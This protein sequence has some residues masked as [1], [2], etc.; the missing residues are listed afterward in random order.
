M[1]ELT[2]FVG[3]AVWA[4]FF[5][6]NVGAAAYLAQR[7]EC[8]HGNYYTCGHCAKDGEVGPHSRLEDLP[9]TNGDFFVRSLPG[10]QLL[11]WWHRPARMR[12]L[13][14][15]NAQQSKHAQVTAASMQAAQDSY[16]IGA[17]YPPFPPDHT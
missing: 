3:V 13:R 6:Y 8:R 11:L 17:T 10:P 9:L 2:L 12:R 5:L 4:I 7:I 1:S 16:R 15:T 14:A